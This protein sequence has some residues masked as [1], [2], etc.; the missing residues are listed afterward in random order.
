MTSVTFARRMFAVAGVYGIIVLAPHYFMEQQIARTHAPINHPEFFYGF[1]GV[2]LA[3]L[4]SSIVMVGMPSVSPVKAPSEPGRAPNF[5]IG[6]LH[7]SA[8][9]LAML[10]PG[11]S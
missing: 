9:R 7:I 4:G 11:P 6:S 10:P 5:L 2:A 8:M 1:T 3:S